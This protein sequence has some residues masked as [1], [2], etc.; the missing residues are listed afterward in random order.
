MKNQTANIITLSRI[1]GVCFIFIWTPFHTLRDQQIVLVLYLLLACTDKLDGVIARSCWGKVTNLGKIIDPLADKILV[2][3]YLP[4]LEMQQITSFP[5]FVL[6][7]RDFAVTSLRVFAA[8]NGEIMAAKFW[9]KAKTCFTLPL[10]AVL[11]C[12]VQIPPSK[13]E[14]GFISPL[15]KWLITWIQSWPQWSITLLIWFMAVITIIS[16]IQYF[17]SFLK[18]KKNRAALLDS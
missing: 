12:R 4:L 16:A 5:V 15:T 8:Q 13:F 11:F 1:I 17:G 9:G 3:V 10:A 14:F 6:L 2:L 7:A 18:N